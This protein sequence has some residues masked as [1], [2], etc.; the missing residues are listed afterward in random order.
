MKKILL[1]IVTALSILTAGACQYGEPPVE[2]V[3][4]Y[5][6]PYISHIN[7]SAAWSVINSSPTYSSFSSPSGGSLHLPLSVRISTSERYAYNCALYGVM[8]Y[9]NSFGLLEDSQLEIKLDYSTD[10]GTTWTLLARKIFRNARQQLINGYSLGRNLLS[11][12]LSPG[13]KI[14]LRFRCGPPGFSDAAF[15]SASYG[16]LV[17]REAPE[18]TGSLQPAHGTVEFV[19]EYTITGPRRPGRN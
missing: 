10:N 9:D 2:Y 18:V 15:K 19:T 8:A 6:I 14:L 13:T 1:F 16:S 3:D 4:G 7:S 11:E 12:N 17:I 5:V